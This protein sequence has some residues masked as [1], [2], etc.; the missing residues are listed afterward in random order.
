MGVGQV[1]CH[2]GP[3]VEREGGA[4]CSIIVTRGPSDD[5]EGWLVVFMKVNAV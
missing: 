4:K 1:D 3:W 5:V 2:F